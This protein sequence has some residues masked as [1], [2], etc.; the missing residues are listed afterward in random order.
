MWINRAAAIH[1]TLEYSRY[2]SGKPAYRIASCIFARF[3]N[4]LEPVIVLKIGK[5]PDKI[6]PC[7]KQS[8]AANISGEMYVVSARCPNMFLCIGTQYIEKYQL[9]E[10][11]QLVEGSDL[12]ECAVLLAEI[13][14]YR[15]INSK[16]INCFIGYYFY[17]YPNMV[18]HGGNQAWFL[19]KFGSFSRDNYLLIW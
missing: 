16:N 3:M 9:L 4:F 19:C 12:I 2:G 17:M 10:N 15:D 7:F 6:Y 5:L 13:H 8:L 18:W 1:R 11:T 14:L